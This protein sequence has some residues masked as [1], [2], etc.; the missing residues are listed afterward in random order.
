[1]FDTNKEI[2]IRYDLD[3]YI[4]NIVSGLSDEEYQEIINSTNNGYL[5]GVV[6]P[7]HIK[8]YLRNA[9]CKM[10]LKSIDN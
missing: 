7:E 6:K 2:V 9:M 8:N 5:S 10:M 1:M 3:E 4:E